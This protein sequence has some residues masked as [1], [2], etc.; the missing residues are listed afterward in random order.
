MYAANY[1]RVREA[2]F[3]ACKA[4]SV[5]ILLLNGD[6]FLYNIMSSTKKHMSR[7]VPNNKNPTGT[8][9]LLLFYGFIKDLIKSK[10]VHEKSILLNL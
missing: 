9:A 1:P 10:K 4:T 6:I 2:L 7:L 3:I 5:P 8:E